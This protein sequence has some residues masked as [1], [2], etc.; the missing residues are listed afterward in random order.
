MSIGPRKSIALIS[1]FLAGGLIF[2]AHVE[3]QSGQ[4]TDHVTV[5]T[6]SGFYSAAQEAAVF[7]PFT[8]ETGVGVRIHYHNGDFSEDGFLSRSSKNPADV[9]DVERADLTHGCANGLFQKIDAA[10]LLGNGILDDFIEGTLHPCGVGAMIWSQAVAYDTTTFAKFPPKTLR[11]F[12]DLENFPGK[13]GM[14]A[15]AEGTLELALMA[16]GIPNQDVYDV[17]RRPGGIE[18]ALAKLD[19]IKSDLVFWRSGE[20]AEKLL[21]EGLVTMTTAYAGRFL[22]PRQ[23]A[24]RPVTLLWD[25][26]LWRATYWAIPT[27]SNKIG[28]AQRFISFATDANRLA[29]LSIRLWFGPA[30]RSGMDAV[31]Q[32]VRAE[33]PTA[34]SKFRT[35]LAVDTAFWAEFG[36]KVEAAFQR[37]RKN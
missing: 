29:E 21:N 18:R 14:F 33:L 3:A 31:P 22:R 23:G 17:L 34:R 2:P 30:R 26:Q 9:V 7:K 8:R 36:P 5:A 11:D 35:A 15:G 27:S 13:R 6:W 16:D 20:G 12:F 19:T 25:H 4:E 24:R 28:N 37:W 1:L 10:E 32:N